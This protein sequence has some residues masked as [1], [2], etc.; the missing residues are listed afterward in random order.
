[1]NRSSLARALDWDDPGTHVPKIRAFQ[2]IFVCVLAAEYWARAIPKWEQLSTLYTTSLGVSTLLAVAVLG[3]PWKRLAFLGLAVT[4]AA[5]V[6]AEFPAAGNHA[7][8][9]LFLCLL[10]AALDGREPD[11]QRLF[12]R[13]V[14]WMVCVIFVYGG[15][16]KWIHGYYSHG[17]FL[18]FSLLTESFRP[19]LRPLLP[20]DEF[21]RL[22]AYTGQPGSGPYLVS[23]P[24]FLIFSHGV[25]L[26]EIALAPL[27]LLPATRVFGLFAA[28]G[29]MAGIEAAARELFFGLVFVN[30]ILC[31]ARTDLNRRLIPVFVSVLIVL[32]LIRAGVLPEMT[33]Y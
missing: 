20:A 28:I 16:Q 13:A 25:Y 14:R 5:V 23:S 10:C 9:E 33:F 2:T 17:Q 7:Y 21:A 1:M 3:T 32:L 26:V 4:Q 24:L 15:L 27:L 18:A 8:L 29:F 31:F 19:V 11:D 22:V 6:W 12:L 30:A